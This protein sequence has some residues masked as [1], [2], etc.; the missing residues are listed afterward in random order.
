MAQLLLG[1]CHELIHNIP[2]A[3]VQLIY[4]DPP[5][6]VTARQPWD[7]PLRLN[8]LWD[9]FWR[10][11][12]PNGTV[13]I[14]SSVPFTV[15]VINSQRK[16]FKYWWTWHKV[17]K[18]N[19]LNSGHQPLR[20]TEEICVFYKQR[21]KYNAQMVKLDTVRRRKSAEKSST[22]VHNY[23]GGIVTETSHD[24]PCTLL[25]IPA[26]TSSLKPVELCDYM[27]RTYTDENDTVLDI[28]MHKGVS[29]IAALRA[30]R[31]YIGIE[32]CPEYYESAQ[33]TLAP[34]VQ[35]VHGVRTEV[36]NPS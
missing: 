25:T 6:G 10:I 18:T 16:H 2:D 15:D 29:G 20:N 26:S 17:K 8:E 1:D 11:L 5:Y 14:H 21:C 30:G 9:H 12:V 22:T 7:V 13:V 33:T 24:H 4:F 19:F 36:P 27:I 28:C 3:S 23:Q 34:L 32:L 35:S 31:R